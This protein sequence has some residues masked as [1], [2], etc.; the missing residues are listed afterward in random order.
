MLRVI[1]CPAHKD[2]DVP[3]NLI[4]GTAWAC[5][6]TEMQECGTESTFYSCLL[7]KKLFDFHAV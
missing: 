7:Q 3:G 2:Q 6:S 4:N 1:R 5:G